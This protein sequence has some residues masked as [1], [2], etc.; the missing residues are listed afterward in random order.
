VGDDGKRI[1]M[2]FR[3]PPRLFLVDVPTGEILKDVAPNPSL[4][5]PLQ[6]TAEGTLFGWSFPRVSD[7]L[8][9]AIDQDLQEWDLAA[10]TLKR[11]IKVR[12]FQAIVPHGD[13][14]LFA[15]HGLLPVVDPKRSSA[16]EVVV[17][18]RDTLSVAWEAKAPPSIVDAAWGL[19]GREVL[20]LTDHRTIVRLPFAPKRQ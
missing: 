15:G 13:Y 8:S 10:G 4:L 5:R 3:H 2:S 12:G 1:A 20:L 17:R 14:I 9:Y 18:R 7:G 19:D 16:A 6:L 11:S